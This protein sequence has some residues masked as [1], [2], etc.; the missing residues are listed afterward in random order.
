MVSEMH[1]ILLLI[2]TIIILSGCGAEEQAES[3]PAVRPVKLFVVAV[4]EPELSILPILLA[5]CVYL[6][7]TLSGIGNSLKSLLL[8]IRFD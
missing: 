1:R 2:S 7:M 3:A 4:T 5:P 8:I 6:L